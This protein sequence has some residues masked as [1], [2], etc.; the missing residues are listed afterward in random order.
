MME[1]IDLQKYKQFQT[2]SAFILFGLGCLWHDL[3]DKLGD[4][5][6]YGVFCPINESVWEH[7]KIVLNPLVVW[8]IVEYVYLKPSNLSYFISVKCYS[9][10]FCCFIGI[11]VLLYIQRHY[12]S[13]YFDS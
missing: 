11:F 1:S 4:Y 12:W 2:I 9:M 6:L 3:L 8:S 10:F 5:F 7:G 13:W